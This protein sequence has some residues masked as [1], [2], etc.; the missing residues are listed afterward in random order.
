MLSRGIISVQLWPRK[1]KV[2]KRSLAF[3]LDQDI[4]IN[5]DLMALAGEVTRTP[6]PYSIMV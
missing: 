3:H 2:Q 1:H 5:K 4:D 6:S